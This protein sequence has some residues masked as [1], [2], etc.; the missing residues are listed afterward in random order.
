[1][2]DEVL[3]IGIEL[4]PIDEVGTEID[5]FG[6]PETGLGFLIHLPDIIILDGEK[7]E[8]IVRFLQDLFSNCF[9]WLLHWES[10]YT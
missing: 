5:L 3:F 2:L 10:L 9:G 7:H 4:G 1:M 8:T 6:G